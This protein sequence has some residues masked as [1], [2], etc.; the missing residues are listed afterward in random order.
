MN[1]VAEG[2]MITH[3][4]VQIICAHQVSSTMMMHSDV[5][6]IFEFI[7]FGSLVGRR[8]SRIRCSINHR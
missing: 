8:L 7:A 5:P 1:G 3:W 2:V 6:D 4:G